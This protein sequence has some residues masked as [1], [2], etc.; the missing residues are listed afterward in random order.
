[1]MTLAKGMLLSKIELTGGA[2]EAIGM[3][4]DESQLAMKALMDGDDAQATTRWQRAIAMAEE[5][6]EAPSAQLGEVYFNLGKMLADAGQDSQAILSLKKSVDMLTL[7]EP[8]HQRLNTAKYQL[9]ALLRK[10]GDEDGSKQLFEQALQ[11][12][13]STVTY[14]PLTDASLC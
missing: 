5:A 7:V 1:M 11:I 14:V 4:K 12:A 13:P 6:C 3:W 10:A 9:A 8:G 2:A